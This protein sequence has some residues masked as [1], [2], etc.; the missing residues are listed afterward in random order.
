MRDNFPELELEIIK[1]M[2][3]ESLRE[4]GEDINVDI[5]FGSSKAS[6]LGR[7]MNLPLIRIGFPIHDRFGGQRQMYL[8]YK[9]TLNLVDDIV[10]EFLAIKQME[11]EVG[12]AYL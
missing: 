11:H 3:F 10:N 8:G 2:D 6:P 7:Q 4:K 5:I 1:D 12:Y 9:G